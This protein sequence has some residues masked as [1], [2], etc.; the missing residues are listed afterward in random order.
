MPKKTLKNDPKHRGPDPKKTRDK[1]LKAAKTLFVKQGFAGTAMREIA[2]KAKVTQSLLH[3]HFGTKESL[4]QM[5]KYE[6]T[7][8]YFEAIAEQI[9]AE[10]HGKNPASIK[11]TL[12]FRFRFMQNNP[13]LIRMSLWQY[14]DK[15]K[16]HSTT[17]GRDLLKHLI[18]NLTEDQKNNKL[19]NDIDPTII[20][21]IMF[22]LTT[23]WFQQNYDWILKQGK[24]SSLN[25]K[26][27]ADTYLEAIQKILIKGLAPD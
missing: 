19:R 22:I 10:Q 17:K 16:H 14:L 27:A 18:E 13:E 24:L 3:H 26:E 1:I 9:E 7:N 23:G 2:V 12:E 20:T 5:V 8:R 6:L 21:A 11:D 25:E 15:Y 4:W